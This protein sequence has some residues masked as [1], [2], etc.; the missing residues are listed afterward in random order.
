VNLREF[1]IP[2]TPVN[3]L[4]SMRQTPSSVIMDVLANPL[5]RNA[6]WLEEEAP[7]SEDQEQNK[8]LVRRLYEAQT[9]GDLY[10][11]RG[12]PAPDFDDHWLAPGQEEPGRGA[13]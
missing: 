12:L 6:S 11:M 4:R 3:R 2:R 8:A 1:L 7:V 13:T 9:K 5:E 10:A